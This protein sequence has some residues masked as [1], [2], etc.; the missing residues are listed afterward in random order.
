MIRLLP[1][2]LLVCAGIA[3]AVPMS[4]CTGGGYV[5]TANYPDWCPNKLTT[6]DTAPSATG[7][8]ISVTSTATT[9]TTYVSIRTTATRVHWRTVINGTGDEA[10]ASAAHSTSTVS[11][12]VTGLANSTPYFA[13][14]VNTYLNKPSQYEV[15][16]F[17]T[18]ASGGGGGGGGAGDAIT[19]GDDW[20][21]CNDASAS[22][23]NT[24][25]SHAQRRKSLPGTD[26][27]L[28][29]GDDM[30]LCSGGVW[31]GQTIDISRPGDT[32]GAGT[33]VDPDLVNWAEMGTY[34]MDGSTEK[35]AVD[36]VDGIDTT[37]A[38]AAIRGGLTAEC[39]QAKSC[40]FPVFSGANATQDE[41]TSQYDSIV[42]VKTTAWY[43]KFE[44]ISIMWSVARGMTVQGNNTNESHRYVILDGIDSRQNG[45]NNVVFTR[46]VADFV[47]RNGDYY[48]HSLCRVFQKLSN[49]TNFSCGTKNTW[50]ASVAIE[51]RVRRGLVENNEVRDT[52][53]EG[54]NCNNT[55]SSS[56]GKM[57]FRANRVVNTWSTQLYLDGCPG[58]VVE[59]NIVLGGTT[60]VVGV[61]R[62]A[63][64]FNSIN[65][66]QE[67]SNSP[68]NIGNVVRNNLFVGAN[69]FIKMDQIELP[70]TG[71]GGKFYGNTL[72]YG[73][74]K[75]IQIYNKQT[76]PDA[77]LEFDLRNNIIWDQGLGAGACT[78]PTLT[79]R[80]VNYN[81]WYVS[82]TDPECQDSN[83]QAS[84]AAPII[85][86]N[87]YATWQ[88]TAAQQGTYPV[89]WPTFSDVTP[90]GTSGQNIRDTGTPLTSAILDITNFG[91][92]WEQIAE[93]RAAT[94]TE[95]NWEC[96][97]CV[98]ATGATRSGSPSKGAV[99]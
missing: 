28:D 6:I 20:F 34:V 42:D 86:Q 37:D 68:A 7:A 17:N 61:S 36:G 95:A 32:T 64:A 60:N 69:N 31:T 90:N 58:S 87:N 48:Q 27:G 99:E 16:A 55:I 98:D 82:Q 80:T 22:D 8:T 59:N 40:L 67:R 10:S 57:I 78:I 92:A 76:S 63:S 50:G 81:H 83:P 54:I 96:A 84:F 74:T 15:V 52:Y 4:Q 19:G 13:H 66:G 49:A 46:G 97:L 75:A 77:V 51:G 26:S 39:I 79:N 9:G 18:E 25:R 11:I 53:G 29:D 44:N 21:Y 33:P 71:V 45:Y 89:S 2:I 23:A 12:A 56:D 1:L 91:W 72:I 14:V 35:K 24:G 3:N 85:S 38:K 73:N 43:N 94:L 47:V 30:W 41:L 93:V 70:T 62:T 88:T 65:V 5:P